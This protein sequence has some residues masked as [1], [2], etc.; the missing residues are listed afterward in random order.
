MARPRLAEEEI[1]LE[2]EPRDIREYLVNRG[3]DPSIFDPISEE[4]EV[5]LLERG[6]RL[7][8]L[9]LAEYC[10]EKVTAQRIFEQ[11][12]PILRGLVLSNQSV[13]KG[14]LLAR[15]PECLFGGKTEMLEALPSL[16]AEE[17][18]VMFR[19]PSMDDRFLED[20]LSLG[21]TW[22]ALAP[23]NRIVALHNLAAN[24]K[25]RTDRS[26]IDYEDG[27]DWYSSGLPVVAAWALICKLEPNDEIA[28]ALASLLRELPADNFKKEEIVDCIQKWTAT[29]KVLEKEATE[30]ARGRLSDFQEIRQAGS[31]LLASDW[32]API[33]EYLAS[34]D[35]AVRCG[36]YEG[37]KKLDAE[38]IVAAIERDGDLARTHLIRN[39]RLWRSQKQ[40]N[41][42]VDH[43]LHGTTS[44]E[45]RWEFRRREASYRKL[46]PR[47]F[48]D[49]DDS[50]LEPDERPIAESSLAD[51]VRGVTNNPSMQELQR[52]V[53]QLE[54][55]QTLMTLM[56][57]AVLIIL[58]GQIWN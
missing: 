46:F 29:G 24:E 25:M 13:A 52:R 1:L 28:S 9:T 49:E 20:F 44:E 58:I 12:D 57:G 39:P 21:N 17:V 41:L 19:N 14:S 22:L 27:W 3:R 8:D 55:G 54:K 32:N 37:A 43:A 42:L 56:L 15:F 26:T 7:I 23:A 35:V 53:A 5:A 2:S 47:W 45:P 6:N 4:A 10:L 18:A 31:R 16:P 51:I 50:Y 36:V 40:R 30:N 33:A 34:D 11:N 48:D 38:L